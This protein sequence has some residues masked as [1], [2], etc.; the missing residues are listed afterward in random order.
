MKKL[1]F[2]PNVGSPENFVRFSLDEMDAWTPAAKAARTRLPGVDDG[3][4]I[5][6]VGPMHQLD[7]PFRLIPPQA[8]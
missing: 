3:W 7:A 1:G 4:I 2:E 5:H 6:A 8:A